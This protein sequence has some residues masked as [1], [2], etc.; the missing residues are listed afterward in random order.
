M[1]K[2]RTDL[3]RAMDCLAALAQVWDTDFVKRKWQQIAREWK[4]TYIP[5]KDKELMKWMT[6]EEQELYLNAC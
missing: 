4:R 5:A 3:W 1:K 6:P 2:C